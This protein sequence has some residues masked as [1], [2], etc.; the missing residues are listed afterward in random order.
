MRQ[1]RKA[2]DPSKVKRGHQFVALLR[3]GGRHADPP[4]PPRGTQRVRWRKEL[5]GA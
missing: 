1:G 3:R 4:R 5:A 2:F